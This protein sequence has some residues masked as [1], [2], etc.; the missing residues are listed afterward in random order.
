MISSVHGEILEL[1]G[2]NKPD[3]NDSYIVPGNRS[4]HMEYKFFIV[5]ITSDLQE[6]YSAEN[7]F[8]V[9]CPGNQND[10]HHYKLENL[11]TTRKCQTEK[12]FRF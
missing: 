6:V 9:G 11:Y 5:A 2:L 12:L 1:D 4:A 7:T 3:I 8:V 10:I